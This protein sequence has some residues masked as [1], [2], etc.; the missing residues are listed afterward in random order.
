MK[1]FIQFI[2]LVVLTSVM[3]PVVAD[4]QQSANR[5]RAQQAIEAVLPEGVT[6]ATATLEQIEAAIASLGD[7]LSGDDFAELSGEMAAIFSEA[8]PELAASTAAAIVRSAPADHVASVAVSVAANSA[9]SSSGRAGASSASQIAQ[10]VSAA[11][12]PRGGVPSQ[13]LAQAIVNSVP[14]AAAEIS[15]TMNVQV[16]AP[17]APIAPPSGTAPVPPAPA[18]PTTVVPGP[19]DPIED[20]SDPD[21][22][23]PEDPEDPSPMAN[24]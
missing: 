11:A 5:A 4:A 22:E 17:A 2:A 7:S 1:P 6:L 24:Q 19:V 16:T 21:I 15:E 10:S 20:D 23:V 14:T 9:V 12:A 13:A 8:R 18:D 3:A